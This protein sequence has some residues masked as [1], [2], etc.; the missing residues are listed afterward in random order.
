MMNNMPTGMKKWHKTTEPQSHTRQPK[1]SPPPL[2]P[3]SS[4]SPSDR[5][6]QNCMTHSHWFL[7]ETV[8]FYTELCTSP[9][10]FHNFEVSQCGSNQS[11]KNYGFIS[12]TMRTNHL[13]MKQ[14]LFKI[15]EL[16]IRLC[17]WRQGESLASINMCWLSAWREP[18]S[19][20]LN[21]FML[22]KIPT[23]FP[24]F[25]LIS[26]YVFGLVCVILFR[27]TC[28]LKLKFAIYHRAT[29]LSS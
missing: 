21:C 22:S 13:T 24:C 3:S 8:A 2:P 6:I 19:C 20:I 5:L 10:L 4:S 28:M 17:T 7:H 26:C 27:S 16:E 18:V 11:L 12:N 1:C 15:V 25:L 29:S 9:L 23:L 14:L